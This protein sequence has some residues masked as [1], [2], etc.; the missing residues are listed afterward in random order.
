M[1]DRYTTLTVVL[2]REIREDDAEAIIG[3][4]RMVKGVLRVKGNIPDI[5]HYAAVELA[6][7]EIRKE[8]M[9]ILYKED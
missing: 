9:D 3:A 2:D 5:G 8:I 7:S 4:I 1:T 6:K